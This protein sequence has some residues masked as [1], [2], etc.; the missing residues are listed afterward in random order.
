MNL[1]SV[2]T[3]PRI[4]FHIPLKDILKSD[5]FSFGFFIYSSFRILFDLQT[6]YISF[7]SN[8]SFSNF[9]SFSYFFHFFFFFCTRGVSWFTASSQPQ[10]NIKQDT[11]TGHTLPLGKVRFKNRFLPNTN[12]HVYLN[13]AVSNELKKNINKESNLL[14]MSFLNNFSFLNIN[15]DGRICR[16]QFS[17]VQW[18]N[19]SIFR[20]W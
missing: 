1:I 19:V 7:F 4:T 16:L 15:L 14:S 13:H 2:F 10:Q 9:F 11:L 20:S 3:N 12:C 6:F 5:I 18:S 8:F 17:F